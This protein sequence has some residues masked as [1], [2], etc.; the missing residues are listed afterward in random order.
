MPPT[1]EP[2]PARGW[3]FLMTVLSVLLRFAVA[4][5]G[6]KFVSLC[7]ATRPQPL[8]GGPLAPGGQLRHVGVEDLLVPVGIDVGRHGDVGVAHELLGHVDGHPRPLQVGA[9]G[10]PQAVGGEVRGNGV[11]DHLS[12]P[13]FG[14]HAQ[15][16]VPGK[17]VPQPPQA[18]GAAHPAPGRGKDRALRRP[19]GRQEAVSQLRAHGDIPR[20]PAGVLGALMA[21]VPLSTAL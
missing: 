5:S 8:G 14:P 15:V 17:G 20:T 10:V 9:E 12:V 11:L 7:S 3:F 2:S 1:P 13:D 6:G 4:I 18:V 19:T 16:Q 21:R